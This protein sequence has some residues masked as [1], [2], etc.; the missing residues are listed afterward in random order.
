MAEIPPIMTNEAAYLKA[1]AHPARLTIVNVLRHGEA[2]VCHLEA[3]L[4]YRQSY[5]S[6]QL[7]VLRTAGLVQERR[8]GWN[9]YYSVIRQELFEILDSVGRLAGPRTNNASES[10]GVLDNCPCP[11]CN[12]ERESVAC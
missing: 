12:S 3:A 8:E 4:G 11:H 6:Q 9:I 7:S 10:R 2:C 1:L 5:I